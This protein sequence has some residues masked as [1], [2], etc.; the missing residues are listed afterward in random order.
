M[1]STPFAPLIVAFD[2][3][4]LI[5]IRLRFGTPPFM[6]PAVAFFYRKT[7]GRGPRHYLN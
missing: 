3:R 1:L 4:F 6:P 7:G 2:R 5:I